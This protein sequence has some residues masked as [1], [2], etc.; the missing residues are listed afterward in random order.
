MSLHADQRAALALVALAALAYALTYTFDDVPA[1]IRQGMG[2]EVFP[3]LVAIV[4]MVLAAVLFLAARN[5]APAE[6]PRIERAVPVV[7]I[8]AIAFMAA[9][10]LVGMPVA[11]G[12][13]LVSLGI[14]WGERRWV[15]LLANAILLPLAIWAMF[16]KVLK[17]QLPIGE[18][19]RLLGL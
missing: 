1:S 11:M 3:R 9:V 14:L 5:R 2:P 4:I 17:V 19:G 18:A 16:V 15:P 13:G 6:L 8:G 10:W 12:L 7:M